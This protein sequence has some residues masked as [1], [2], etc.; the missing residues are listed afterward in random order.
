MLAQIP[1]KKIVFDPSSSHYDQAG[2]D[3]TL[4]SSHCFITLKPNQGG[5]EARDFASILQRMIEKYCDK[6]RF[7]H[8]IIE[9]TDFII[10][11]RVQAS[12]NKFEFLNGM[13]KLVRVSPFG[14][15]DKVH[16]S[17]CKVMITAP[18]EKYK[19]QIKETDVR[20][21][22]FI[23]TG[24]GGQHRNK[25]MSAVRLVH[26][27][28]KTIVTSSAERSQHDNRRYAYEQ[29]QMKLEELFEQKQTADRIATRQALNKKED[30]VI[31]YYFNHNFVMN[32]KKS[33]KS[34]K[35]KQILNGELDLIN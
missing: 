11:L 29:L 4:K 10:V 7:I 14:K 34:A 20:M 18:K 23:A 35:L 19:I 15:G 2:R 28:T 31:S 3:H 22:F 9:Q 17:L 16:T 25:T 24:P 30:T 5:L 32:D 1:S 27:P 12:A 33:I 8:E 13:H 6:K 26:L 21:D